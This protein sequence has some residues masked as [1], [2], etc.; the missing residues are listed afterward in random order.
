MTLINPANFPIRSNQLILGLLTSAA[1]DLR[2]W[3]ENTYTSA[4]AANTAWL[5]LPAS[6]VG[7]ES[8]RAYA[9]MDQPVAKATEVMFHTY[10]AAKILDETETELQGWKGRLVA[11]EILAAL[12]RSSVIDGVEA[13]LGA[14][15]IGDGMLLPKVLGLT[16]TISWQ[17]HGP[18]VQRNTRLL[19]D[20]QAWETG[21]RA[22]LAEQATALAQVA[23]TSSTAAPVVYSPS[24]TLTNLDP[25][26]NQGW[27]VPVAERRT[28]PEAID[29][30]FRQVLSDLGALG[31]ATSGVDPHDRRTWLPPTANIWDPRFQQFIGHRMDYAHEFWGG[32]VD[33]VG[34]LLL[35]GPGMVAQQQRDNGNTNPII[36]FFAQR[37]DRG[38]AA[39]LSIFAVDPDSPNPGHQWSQDPI[40]TGV[41]V[42]GGFLSLPRGGP[43]ASLAKLGRLTPNTPGPL[44][45][46]PWNTLPNGPFSNLPNNPAIKSL[47]PRLNINVTDVNKLLNGLDAPNSPRP[48]APLTSPG[49]RAE[50]TAPP[51]TPVDDVN[52]SPAQIARTPDTESPGAARLDENGQPLERSGDSAPVAHH[53]ADPSPLP[54]HAESVDQAPTPPVIDGAKVT[55][56][57]PTIVRGSDGHPHEVWVS[58]EASSRETLSQVDAN[59]G[60]PTAA[61]RAE[62]LR[63]APV[64]Q[65]GTLVD[66]RSGQ[67]LRGVDGQ[68]GT[69]YARWETHDSNGTPTGR[70]IAENPGRGFLEPRRWE[71]IEP[72]PLR[73]SL[74]LSYQS[75]DVRLPGRFPPSMPDLMAQGTKGESGWVLKARDE[76]GME[77]QAQIAGVPSRSPEGSIAEYLVYDAKTQQSVVYDGRV[78]RGHPPIETL[79]E[80]KE[81][82]SWLARWP[83][84]DGRLRSRVDRLIE[85]ANRQLAALPEG[86]RLEWHVSDPLGAAGIQHLFDI[87]GIDGIDV[88]YTPKV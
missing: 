39:L 44:K 18:S 53:P 73:P 64:D 72:A 81:G 28:V 47:P 63:N 45:V 31:L 68:D 62:A 2:T 67:P 17:E 84:P 57:P 48:S 60:T 12:F 20:Y 22:F 46:I 65:H 77:Y 15:S 42:L 10:R 19:A 36:G 82:H 76:R 87:E 6:Y 16:E 66:H 74:A 86:A 85:E 54:A 29:G 35:L 83:I 7:A 43:L 9:L 13:T 37:G 80:G 55:P 58:N 11:I 21:Y 40:G 23:A 51:R 59:K 5:G 41:M 27:G 33:S 24:P 25:G 1:T 75:T 88:I 30:L 26:G 71:Q 14:G 61:D 34:S 38:T 3:G 52:A 49:Q 4:S 50:P 78:E 56:P 8:E 69:W 70:W 79:L 32:A